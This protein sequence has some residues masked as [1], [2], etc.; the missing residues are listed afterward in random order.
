M[1]G[2]VGPVHETQWFISSACQAET[3]AKA[4]PSSHETWWL[5]VGV[6]DIDA[7][8]SSGEA[9]NVKDEFGLLS[10]GNT[11]DG[12]QTEPSCWCAERI[13]RPQT[14][15][16]EQSPETTSPFGRSAW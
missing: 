10:V 7:L 12:R 15:V 5:R 3:Q 8:R 6:G 2:H 16:G 4:L 1:E 11:E 13:E 9:R 14:Q